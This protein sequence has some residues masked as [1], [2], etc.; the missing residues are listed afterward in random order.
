MPLIHLT[1]QINAP[2]QQ[3][4]DL[5]RSIDFHQESMSMTKEKAIGGRTSGLIGLGEIVVWEAIHFGIKQ[6]LS[7]KITA[8]NAPHSFK[9]E[10]VYGAFKSMKH[11][12]VFIYKDGVTNMIDL[13][14]FESAFGIIGKMFNYFFLTKYM[15]KFLETRNAAIKDAIERNV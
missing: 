10:M 4:F 7:V 3:V 13:F 12:H 5:S 6:K 9:D 14:R 8:M 15:T 2:I 1:T 11:D